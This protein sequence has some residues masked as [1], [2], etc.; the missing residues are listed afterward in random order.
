MGFVLTSDEAQRMLDADPQND[1]VIFPYLNGED[2]NSDPEQRPS[3]WVINFWDW[4]EERARKYVLP[5]KWIEDRVKPERQRLKPNGDFVLRKP[6]PQRWWQYG[7]KRPGLYHAIGRGHSF[8]R[9]PEGW[10][11]TAEPLETVLVCSE[12]TKHLAFAIIPN[13]Y[14]MSAN[15]DVL[16]KI[17]LFGLS[18]SSIHEVWARQYSSRLETRL[19]YSPGNAFETFPFPIS[20][21]DEEVFAAGERYEVLRKTEVADRGL[22]LTKLYNCFHDPSAQDTGIEN[23]RKQHRELDLAVIRAFDWGDLD[24]GHGFHEVPYLPE[25]DRVRF[26]VSETARV[27]VLRRLAE[28]NRQRYQEEVTQRLHEGSSRSGKAGV[29]RSQAGS[30]PEPTLDLEALLTTIEGSD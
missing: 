10:D 4:P 29:R 30:A 5:W 22:G 17:E 2:L 14:V 23:L 3:R 16:S 24:L 6:L 13:Q 28:L 15:L 21:G 26:T 9:H 27:E 18:Q 12:V 25:S 8:E 20:S 1:E 19:K 7:E 11:S